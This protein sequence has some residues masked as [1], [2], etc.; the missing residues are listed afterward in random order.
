VPARPPVHDVDDSDLRISAPKDAAAGPL[1]VA[2]SMKMALDRMGPAKTA[3]TLLALNQTDGFDCMSCAW[4]DPEPGHRHTAEFCEN[5]AKAV[6]HEGTRNK[7]GPDFFAQHSVDDIAG[8]SEYWLTQQGRLTHPVVRRDGGSHYEA[9]SWDDAFALVAQHLNRLETPDQASFY[10]SGRASNEVAFIYQLFARAYGTNNLPD[11][12]NMCHESTS[13]ALQ[14]AIGIGK[15]SVVLQDVYDADLIVINGQNPGTNHPRMLSALEKAKRNGATIVAVNP[16]REAGLLKFNNPQEPTGLVGAGTDLA[17]VYLQIRSGGDMA[18]YQGLAWCLLDAEDRAA[19][20][21]RPGAVVDHDFIERHTVGFAE[22]AEHIRGLDWDDVL[23][24]TG[25]TSGQIEAVATLMAAS[26]RIITCW[27]MGITQHRNAVATIK[28]FVNVCFLQGAIGKPGA[29]L[30]P[31]RG[32]S[33]V[34]GDRTMGIWERAPKH[35]LDAVGAEFGFTPPYEHGL[36]AVDTL[37]AMRDGEVRVFVGLGGNYAAAMS[38]TE[39]ADDAL[40]RCDLTVQISTMLNH[41]HG[42]VGRDALILPTLGRTERDRTGGIE[43]RI[44][45]ED[46]TC[47]VHASRGRVA[48]ASRHLRSEVDIIASIAEATLGD[49]YGIRW[50]DFRRDYD[51]IRDHISRV[52]PGCEAYNEKVKRPGGFVM[53]H[54][55]RDSRSFPTEAG[56]GMFTVSPLQVVTLPPGRLVLQGIRSH[57]QFN[58]TIYGLDDRYRG[59]HN[60]RRVLFIS[61]DDLRELGFE[62]G[63]TVDIVSEW[64]DDAERRVPSFRLVEYSTPKGCVAAYYPEA[65]ALVPLDSTALKSNQPTYKWIVVRLERT[66]QTPDPDPE[67]TKEPGHADAVGSD[68]SHKTEPQPRHLS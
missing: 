15:A 30:F 25:L 35:W 61:R 11:C 8:R 45:V 4:P 7:V 10:T 17:D 37:R 9:I 58:T 50:A 22:W 52:V 36:D 41:S 43:Q 21:G 13:I 57:D 6:A 48:P 12:S 68:D 54:P 27:A 42:V 39:V 26:K 49:R 44:T 31:V 16:L 65:N 64:E 29:G 23:A 1:S 5:G 59:I 46:S 2:I 56:R 40:R 51:V 14:E 62:N 53:P 63:E 60:G 32:H 55:P 24:A 18:L 38:D 28:E 66:G 33:N 3:K 67:A 20:A 47:S 34:Q 19:A